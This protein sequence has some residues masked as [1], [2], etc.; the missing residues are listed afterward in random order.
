MEHKIEDYQQLCDMVARDIA[1]GKVIGWFQGRSEM[2]PRA[3]GNRSLLADPRY[4][5]I[6]DYLNQDI[7]HREWWRPY[8]PAVMFEYVDDWFD[9]EVPEAPSSYMN[10]SFGYMLFNAKVLRPDVVPGITHQDKT[11]R[12]QIVTQDMNMK[13]WKLLNAFFD[14]TGVPILLNTSFNV[15]GEPIVETPKDALRT[16]HNSKIDILV[17]N[18]YYIKD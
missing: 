18:N 16:F 15:G 7:K 14:F 10:R 11:A 9:I 4:E 1:H 8:A 6:K 17:M 5:V 3:L 12:V 2:G 13:F